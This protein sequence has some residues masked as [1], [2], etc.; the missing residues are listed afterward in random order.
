MRA[1]FASASLSKAD[2]Y[3]DAIINHAARAFDVRF[4]MREA[5]L[6]NG[7]FDRA[8]TASGPERRELSGR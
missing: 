6:T 1:G 5:I 4:F 8:M 2:G 7:T 3:C